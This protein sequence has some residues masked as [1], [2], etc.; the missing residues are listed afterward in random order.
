MLID[1]PR[2]HLQSSGLCTINFK[3]GVTIHPHRCLLAR[4]YCKQNLLQRHIFL[5]P[6]YDRRDHP[7]STSPLPMS[8][9]HIHPI[10]VPFMPLLQTLLT[11]KRRNSNSTPPSKPP[12]VK[13]SSGYSRKRVA[14]S[15]TVVA[16]CSSADFPNASGSRS[17]ASYLKFQYAAA[18]LSLSLRNSIS[19][20]L[21][22]KPYSH[23]E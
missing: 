13:L 14:H 16:R 2:T 15:S 4:P 20:I 11:D 6:A 21:P 8:G 1:V 10:D 19:L 5:C 3:S 12:S 9:T 18:S 7:A 17:R 23:K 22:I